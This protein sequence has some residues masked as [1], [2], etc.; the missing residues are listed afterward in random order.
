MKRTK[1]LNQLSLKKETVRALTAD[2]MGSVN[3]GVGTGACYAESG[4]NCN[5]GGGAQLTSNTMTTPGMGTSVLIGSAFG[6][7]G[8]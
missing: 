8:G 2:E 4:R 7:G 6:G 3:G 1:Q 5:Q